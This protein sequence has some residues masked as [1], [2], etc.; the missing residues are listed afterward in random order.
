MGNSTI[1]GMGE[2]FINTLNEDELSELQTAQNLV[3]KYKE[4]Y[5]AFC[6]GTTADDIKKHLSEVAAQQRNEAEACNRVRNR[7]K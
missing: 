4:K 7:F 6:G 3:N 1:F 2:D 5:T